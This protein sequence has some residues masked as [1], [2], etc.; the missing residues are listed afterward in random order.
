MSYLVT[1]G[2]AIAPDRVQMLVWTFV[3]VFVFLVGVLVQDPASIKELP[4]LPNWL[5]ALMGLNSLGYLGGKFVANPGRTSWSYRSSRQLRFPREARCHRRC[6]WTSADQS[7]RRPR[8]LN[9]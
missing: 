8:F 2:G 4:L 3:G 1:R 6:P 9:R 5:M 7:P